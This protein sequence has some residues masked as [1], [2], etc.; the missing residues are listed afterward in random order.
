LKDI[1]HREIFI[2]TILAA[3]VLWMGVYPMP[4]TEVMHTTVDDLLAHVARGKL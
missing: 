4:F 3:A 1:N 2:L